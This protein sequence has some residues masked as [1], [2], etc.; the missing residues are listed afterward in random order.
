MCTLRVDPH[1]S[2][3]GVPISGISNTGRSP[4]ESGGDGAGV[5]TGEGSGGALDGVS[6]E[7]LPLSSPSSLLQTSVQKNISRLSSHSNV[8][9]NLVPSPLQSQYPASSLKITSSHSRSKLVSKSPEHNAPRQTHELETGCE[10]FVVV[11]VSISEAGV[12]V[13][14]AAVGASVC[15][16]GTVV[17]GAK[18]V[19]S[20]GGVVVVVVGTLLVVVVG[21]LVVVIID[22]LVV[23][24]VLLSVSEDVLVT[25]G[26]VGGKVETGTVVVGSS[27]AEV[28][29]LAVVVA[30]SLLPCAGVVVLC[31]FDSVTLLGNAV[32]SPGV[33]A[34]EVV[35]AGDDS[36]TDEPV[37]ETLCSST[38]LSLPT[39]AKETLGRSGLP[40]PFKNPLA[41]PCIFNSSN[42]LPKKTNV[43]DT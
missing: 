33:I 25:S 20:F 5:T 10:D 12:E 27:L 24:V 4:P 31:E 32:V 13:S 41:P 6:L 43:C 29:P 21:R 37:V 30:S 26:G 40:E 34:D 42:M 28:V 2:P 16:G 23:V 8:S 39:L 19:V 22:T 18:V 38:L 9:D 1:V 35:A 15:R 7:P 17:E 11:S 3:H 14:G 36:V